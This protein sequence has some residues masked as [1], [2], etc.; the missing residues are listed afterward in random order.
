MM[1]V[2]ACVMAVSA[3]ACEGTGGPPT[4]PTEE[5]D[6]HGCNPGAPNLELMCLGKPVNNA[7]GDETE[8]Q[9]DISI[10]GRG[11]E[12][13]LVRTYDALNA[14]FSDSS[15]W[16]YGWTGPYGGA[17]LSLPVGGGGIATVHQAN[18]SSVLFYAS[19]E[20]WTQ[21]GWDQGRL[22]KVGTEYVYTLPD[23]TKLSFGKEGGPVLKETERDGN[24]NTLTYKAGKLEKVEDSAKRTLTFK[25]NGEGLVESVKD[26]IGHEVS[27][28]YSG[29]QLASVK[30]EGKERWKFEYES[31]HLLTK[32]TDGDGHVT[33]IKYETA[34]PYRVLEEEVGGHKRKWKYGSGETTITEPNGSETLEK[35]NSANEPTKITRAK[36]KSEETTTEYEYNTETYTPKK[37]IDPNKHVTEY[38]YEAEGNKISE[39]DPNGDE[40]KW[41][42]DKKHDV[43]KETTPEGEVTTIKRNEHGEPEVI[44]RPVGSETQKTE[45]KYDGEGDLTEEID[46]LGHVTKYTYDSHG[47]KETETDA[48]GDESKWKY[49][50]DSQVIEETSPRGYVTKTERDERGLPTKITDPLGHTTEYK[51]DGNGNIESRTDGDGHTTKY[52]Y[53]EEN[54]PTK[55]TEPTG[56]VVETGYDAEG[57]MTSHTDGEK[58]TWEYKRNALEQVTE[59]KSPLGKV[60]KK[61][62]EKAGN[63]EKLEDPEGRTTEYGYDESDRLKKIKYSTGKPSEVTYEYNKDSKVTKMKDETGTTENTWDKLDRLTKYKS[64][65]GKTVEYEYNLDNQPIKTTYPNGK[66]VT[67]EFDKAGRLEKVTDWNSRTTS[68][69]YNK[70]SEL[71]KTIFPSASEDEDTYGYNEAD[72]MTEVK[73]VKGA[74]TLAKL[75]YEHDNDGQ[76]KKTTTTG[77]PGPATS[78]SVL[79]ENNR[80]IEVQGKAYKYSKANDPE[81]I[82]GET[83]YT[84]NSADELEKGGGNTYTYS[85]DGQRTKTKPEE[86]GKPTATYSYNQAGNLT[87]VERPEHEMIPR[88]EDKYTYDGNDLLQSQTNNGTKTNLTWDTTEEL[89]IILEDETNSYIYGPENLP[90]EQIATSGGETTLYLHHDQQGSTRLLTNTGGEKETAY[91]Y[92]PY[93]RTLYTEGTAT[94][95]LRYD[96]EYTS[97]NTGLIYLRARWYDPNTTQFLTT[98]PAL[99]LT[100]EPYAYTTDDPE[101]RSDPSG[102]CQ[103]RDELC[104][105]YAR[106]YI[107][108][109][110]DADT[111]KRVAREEYARAREYYAKINENG[112]FNRI[113]NYWNGENAYW[114][115]LGDVAT[116]SGDAKIKKALEALASANKFR[117]WAIELGCDPRG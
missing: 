109:L 65:A 104:L 50:E 1:L 36:G 60:W 11:P 39:K 29:K 113:W 85:E 47:D 111:W 6:G 80:L 61:T 63:L 112:F 72:Q 15:V 68:F 81:E 25:Y 42:Y 103:D 5:E 48:E 32:I 66:A 88:I 16:G 100:G 98:D 22:A 78:E 67:H 87:A 90:I 83:G 106:A 69:K 94:T 3:V 91:S 93:G 31:P 56:T 82:E 105:R 108:F 41:E 21:G 51:Y 10:G 77:L 89:P 52:E 24:S 43:I 64:G 45:Y 33:R 115:G 49:N 54:L 71:E 34:L 58:H 30:I 95:S 23:Q 76:V 38:G 9:T 97:T 74:T 27:Y 35:F 107:H 8:E 12:L 110:E 4:S 44:E 101:N 17:S 26:P 102:E 46:P 57:Q 96:A 75:N 59:E 2:A 92:S 99:E 70:D 20:T 19:G 117:K 37:L 13:R 18:G 73:M 116:A 55:T 14:A 53:N 7:S 79:D 86:A 114:R 62:Y 84:Y 40:T 28:T